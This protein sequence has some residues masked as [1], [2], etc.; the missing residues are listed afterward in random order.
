MVEISQPDVVVHRRL[1]DSDHLHFASENHRLDELG[2]L[3]Q[4]RFLEQDFKVA[5]LFRVSAVLHSGVPPG[6]FSASVPH[7]FLSF[8][9]C[10]LPYALR[11]SVADFPSWISDFGRKSLPEPSGERQVCFECPNLFRV[12]QNTTCYVR[13]NMNLPEVKLSFDLQPHS[14]ASG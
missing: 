12:P 13:L 10:F 9:Y 7:L 6:L 2:M 11:F 8:F 3:F 1:V 4:S 5:V 14:S